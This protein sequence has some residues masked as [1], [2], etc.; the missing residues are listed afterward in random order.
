MSMEGLKIL[1]LSP[2][3]RTYEDIND[4]PLYNWIKLE[5]EKELK[6]VCINRKYYVFCKKVAKAYMKMQSQFFERYLVKTKYIEYLRDLQRLNNSKC[7]AYMDEDRSKIT[8][9]ES[10]ERNFNEKWKKNET[11]TDM[12]ELISMVEV[13]LGF[14]VDIK[15]MTV[16]SFY[17][18]LNIINRKFVYG[19]KNK[20]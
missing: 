10:K 16:G 13:E 4:M 17:N 3:L 19:Q 6:Y 12:Y 8:I 15:K 7:D 18:H 2:F 14:Q 1:L 5:E 11:K 9:F 20:N